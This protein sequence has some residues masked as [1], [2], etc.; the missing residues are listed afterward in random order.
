MRTSAPSAW[1]TPL[2]TDAIGG[3]TSECEASSRSGE[4]STT[5]CTMRRPGTTTVT[6]WP[7]RAQQPRELLGALRVLVDEGD[8]AERPAR[9]PG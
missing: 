5:L 1:R 3:S 9:P 7:G 6:R 8:V 4:Q 2:T